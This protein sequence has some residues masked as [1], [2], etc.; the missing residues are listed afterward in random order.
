MDLFLPAVVALNRRSSR[1][2]ARASLRH[3]DG[4]HSRGARTVRGRLLVS[5]VTPSVLFRDTSAASAPLLTAPAPDVGSQSRG[6]PRES[7]DALENL[8]K[9]VPRQVA[10]GELQGEVPG[11]PDE[12]SARP[13]Q[14]L[15][16]AREGPTL[17]GD[18]QDQPTQQ[19]AEVVG[20]HPEEQPD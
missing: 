12:A 20:D 18:R 3:V 15:L 17:D 8:T 9:E 7:L 5:V 19:I 2:S 11:M 6:A 1:R 16:E 10:S 14:P 4:R 13:E